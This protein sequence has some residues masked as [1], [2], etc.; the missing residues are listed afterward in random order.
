MT[1]D[2]SLKEGRTSED[3]SLNEGRASEDNSLKEGRASLGL[4][5]QRV[6]HVGEAGTGC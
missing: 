5:F 3:N 2:N 4:Q 6:H 1:E